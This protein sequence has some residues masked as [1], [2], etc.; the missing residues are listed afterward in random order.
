MKPT[1]TP[2]PTT[3]EFWERCH[4]AREL[5]IQRCER[6]DHAMFYPRQ[7][8]VRCASRSL[9]TQPVAGTATVYSYTVVSQ[10]PSREFEP[11]VP[12]LI[13]LIEL[14]E[15][16]RLMANVLT[17]A[18]FDVEIGMPV[19]LTFE[20]RGPDVHIPQFVPA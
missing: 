14:D 20:Q 4:A 3:R 7:A 5:T 19:R 13:A 17:D 9:V 10:A 18:P 8:C 6:C 2:T 16:P 11:A 15:G 12:Y 1:P